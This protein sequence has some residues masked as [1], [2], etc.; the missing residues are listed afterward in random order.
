M[1]AA[2][3]SFEMAIHIFRRE[4]TYYW[5]RR[6]PRSLAIC[7]GRPHVLLSLRTTSPVMA[8]RLA[9]QLDAIL[10]DAAMLAEN[11]DLHL[12]RS[13]IETML[14]AVVERHLT[15]LERVAL[16]A[17]N[18]SG[19]D[20]DQARSDD[21]RALWTYTLLDAQGAM[22]VV[23]QEDRLRMIA[24]G[25]SETDIEAVDRHLT[26]LQMH[27]LV[28]TKHHVLQQMIEGVAAA[29]TAMN[30]SVAQGTYFRGMKLALAEIDR[31][32]GGQRVEDRDAVDRIL[33]TRSDPRP[34]T[35]PVAV[36]RE[37]RRPDRPAGEPARPS[38]VPISEFAKFAE[39]VITLNGK[40]GHWDSKTQRQARSVSNLFVKF[41][42]ED[43]HVN[44]LNQ[45]SQS[46]VGRFADLLSL[47]IYKHY[48]KSVRDEHLTIEQ[49]REKGR[50]LDKN[51][52]QGESKCGLSSGTVNRHFTFIGQIF[53]HGGARGLDNLLKIDLSKL[54]N[55][56]KRETRGRDERLKLPIERAVAIFGTP[57]F[58]NCAAWNALGEPGLP[59]GRQIFHCALY[60]VPI[61]IYY[62]GCRRE[63]LC[64]LMVDDVIVDNGDIPYLHIAKNEFRRIKNIQSQRNVPLHPEVIRLNFL[65]YVK[66]IKTL[67]CK[68]LFPDLFSPSTRSPLGDRFYKEFKPI[69]VSAG[70]TE[71]GLGSHAVRHLFGA[72]LKKK[73][74]DKEGRADLLGHGGDTETSERYC[75]PH[76]IA[77]LLKFVKEL[78]MVTA[79]LQPAEINLIPWVALKRVAPFSQPSR[80]KR[81]A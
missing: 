38:V 29:P 49:L 8:R 81:R 76:E 48:G 71:E 26:M 24:D 47:E 79:D 35:E 6:T 65:E 1:S 64:G 77:T 63:E 9:T 58:N 19:F 43:Q 57:P 73:L 14:S 74:V 80:S 31:R 32:Y 10:E 2:Q 21:M 34:L 45:L 50:E 17:K 61:L 40:N 55:K 46:H 41:M 18:A 11:A 12:S 78:P 5:R 75:E 66:A 30:I 72:Q 39:D 44:D 7:L 27:G 52:K 15:K 3:V 68:L 20:V 4:A 16:A 33:L 23:R 28:P 54:R 13:Q 36:D 70:V 59:G 53:G 69:L 60:F 37:E 62:T 67:G 56:S 42:T 51:R 22:A 25:L